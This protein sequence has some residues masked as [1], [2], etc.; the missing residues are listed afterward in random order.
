MTKPPSGISPARPAP[1]SAQDKQEPTLLEYEE[2]VSAPLWI[3]ILVYGVFLFLIGFLVLYP[4]FDELAN[5]TLNLSLAAVFLAIL[6]MVRLFLS[7]R[8][9][10]FSTGIQFGYSLLHKRFKYSDVLDCRPYRYDLSD[11]LGWGIRKGA[12][13]SVLYNVPGDRGLAVRLTVREHDERK[14]YAFS[15]KRPE[16]IS[17]RVSRHL[18]PVLP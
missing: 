8:I 1:A 7:L 9:S 2:V 15:A 14:V 4:L 3:R 11:Y 13:G 5:E 16:V 18:R 10:V 17:K 6:F 12:D